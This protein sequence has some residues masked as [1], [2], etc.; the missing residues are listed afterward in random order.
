MEDVCGKLEGDGWGEVSDRI[1]LSDKA[2]LS[3]FMASGRS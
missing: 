2:P 3:S 1:V